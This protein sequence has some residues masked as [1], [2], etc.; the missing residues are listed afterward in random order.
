MRFKQGDRLIGVRGL[1]HGEAGLL[2]PF[3]I[4]EADDL[5]VFDDQDR[6]AGGR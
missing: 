6:A 5:L 4:V 1:E 3:A 2:E